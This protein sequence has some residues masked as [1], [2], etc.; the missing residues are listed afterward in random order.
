MK[1]WG[2]IMGAWGLETEVSGNVEVGRTE[3]D[4]RAMEGM[5]G[6]GGHVEG[7]D[8]EPFGTPEGRHRKEVERRADFKD[9]F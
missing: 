9:V 3:D 5:E 8:G 2:M 4:G 6:V 7:R 1:A